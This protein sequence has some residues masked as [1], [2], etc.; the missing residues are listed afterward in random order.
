MTPMR[1]SKHWVLCTVA[2]LLALV[3]STGCDTIE[4]GDGTIEV[5]GDCVPLQPA[6][7]TGEGVRFVNGRCVPD[8][9]AIC[10]AGT[11]LEGD[12]G[13]CVSVGPVADPSPDTGVD[14]DAGPDLPVE[15]GDVD[16]EGDVETDTVGD[17]DEEVGPFE[18][19]CGNELEPGVRVCIWGQTVDFTTGQPLPSNADPPLEVQLKDLL[20]AL[21][22]PT[23]V[24]EE[25]LVLPGGHFILP[26][27]SLSGPPQQL[28]LIVGEREPGATVEPPGQVW[29]RAISGLIVTS[30][31]V[32][33]HGELRLFTVPRSAVAAWNA[34]LDLSPPLPTLETG[35]FLLARILDAE[36]RLPIAG[37]TFTHPDSQGI[38]LYYF[39]DAALT[40][41]DPEQTVTGPAGVALL[42]GTT[43]TDF[44]N[45]TAPGYSSTGQVNCGVSAGRVSIVHVLMLTD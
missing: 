5:D 15:V 9:T 27:V 18:P 22:D 3:T 41:L 42:R 4:C 39:A 6:N 19:V 35:G 20:V 7:C 45:A 40:D 14:V 33:E 26:E 34:E 17:V 21:G 12:T 11:R 28:L 37:A 31:V 10:G 13:Q 8:F 44:C 32:S 30:G 2:A 43:P 1:A 16:D 25:T 38:E 23:A 24:V 36:T 29:Q